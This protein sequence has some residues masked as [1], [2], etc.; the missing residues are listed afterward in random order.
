MAGSKEL[1]IFFLS[2]GLLRIQTLVERRS[3]NCGIQY[4][5]SRLGNSPYELQRILAQLDPLDQ[6]P[7]DSVNS[8]RVLLP[9]PPKT[10]R[11][12]RRNYPTRLILKN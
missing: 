11:I 3:Y 1:A 2:E 12:A 6:L 9:F 5:Y 4:R 7:Q 10:Y 8:D